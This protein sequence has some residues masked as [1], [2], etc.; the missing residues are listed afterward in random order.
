[1]QVETAF[2]SAFINF[3]L[4]WILIT[5]SLSQ[6]QTFAQPLMYCTVVMKHQFSNRSQHIIFRLSLILFFKTLK[7]S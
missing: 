1:M 3:V 2:S 6:V 5:L 7:Q 4:G